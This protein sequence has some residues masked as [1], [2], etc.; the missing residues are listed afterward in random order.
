M[1]LD[2]V[3][4]LTRAPVP[5]EDG[6]V[7]VHAHG[8]EEL[9]VAAETDSRDSANRRVTEL[10]LLLARRRVPDAHVRVFAN[11]TAGA[12]VPGV[13]Y[14]E[15]LD[16]VVVP[17]EEPLRVRV[18]VV[19]DSQSR[20]EVNNLAGC[21]VE[22]VV[23]EAVPRVAVDPRQL[24]G[25]VRRLAR[26][27]RGASVP[28]ARREHPLAT[29]RVQDLSVEPVLLRRAV[30]GKRPASNLRGHPHEPG[31][32][33]EKRLGEHRVRQG[34]VAGLAVLVKRRPCLSVGDFDAERFPNLDESLHGDDA[35]L[36]RVDSR[37]GVRQQLALGAVQLAP[38][39]E[40][41]THLFLE[42][43]QPVTHRE[44]MPVR[45]VDGFLFLDAQAPG[46][47][48][49]RGDGR[50]LTR[51]EL[52]AGAHRGVVAQHGSPLQVGRRDPRGG[53]RDHDHRLG[54]GDAIEVAVRFA[55]LLRLPE[56]RAVGLVAL[57]GGELRRQRALP[58]GLRVG[59]SG[60]A[61]ESD[62]DSLG[63][64]N[65]CEFSTGDAGLGGYRRSL[66]VDEGLDLALAASFRAFWAASP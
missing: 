31:F 9:G 51:G 47:L 12:Q 2:L 54:L 35:S 62:W 3:H 56:R 60:H 25:G 6:V 59:A 63:T 40:R 18:F 5:D 34:P 43:L 24:H 52:A 48:G 27:P 1:S 8:R 45:R 44:V 23:R 20:G 36:V 30:E 10:L 22:E 7:V 65:G 21:G 61:A 64:G 38:G 53:L 15:A 58:P 50:R 46:L 16:V 13:G 49:E 66:T 41:R 39:L 11:L 42:L 14:R 57:H 4:A 55:E 26:A 17:G 33:H 28:A 19:H 32:P 29:L 37:E